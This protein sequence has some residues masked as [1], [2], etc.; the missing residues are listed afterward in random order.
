GF[1]ILL[2]A[3]EPFNT[4]Y[5]WYQDEGLIPEKQ[6]VVI[7]NVAPESGAVWYEID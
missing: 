3:V 4:N 7:S 1:N 6:R 2:S 5:V